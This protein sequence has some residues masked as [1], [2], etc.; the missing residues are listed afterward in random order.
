MGRKG[1]ASPSASTGRSG[2]TFPARLRWPFSVKQRALA[3]TVLALV[4]IVAVA[5]TRE[6]GMAG[7]GATAA[8]S[9]PAAPPRPAFTPDEEA[10]IRALWPIHGEVERSTVRLALGQIFYKINDMDRRALKAR[11]DEA[12]ATYRRSEA[13]LREL[14][15][16]RSMRREH[17]EYLAAIGLFQQSATEILKMFSDGRDNHLVAAYPLGQQ[18]ADKIREVGGKFWPGEFRPH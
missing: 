7:R 1:V 11:A 3:A 18:A 15:P 5:L 16:P 13:R 12:L 14:E 9:R 8:V 6:M 17:L 4:A 2:L 10:Y